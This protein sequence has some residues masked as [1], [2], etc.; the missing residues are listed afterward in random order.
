M[1]LLSVACILYF[2]HCDINIAELLVLATIVLS[3]S[4]AHV[5]RNRSK[6]SL[7]KCA[8]PPDPLEPSSLNVR[9][10]SFS[11]RSRV[12]YDINT[13]VYVVIFIQIVQGSSY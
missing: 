5:D 6:T 3:T 8:D 12:N 4:H 10:I 13:F 7:S 2:C 1:Y 9:G 11:A